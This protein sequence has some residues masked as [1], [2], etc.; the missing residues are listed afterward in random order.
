V[1]AGLAA[2]LLAA[3][4]LAAAQKWIDE[5]G[6]VY[7]GTPPPGLAVKPAPLTGGTSS[8][9]GSQPADPNFPPPRYAPVEPWQE[10]MRQQEYERR[11]VEQERREAEQRARDEAARD[12]GIERRQE[13]ERERCLFGR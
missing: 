4:P 5:S 2:L 11:R 8:S 6:K 7:Y 1:R 12:A 3:S 13:E 9:V 10:Q